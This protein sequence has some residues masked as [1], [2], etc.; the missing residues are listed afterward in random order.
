MKL[1]S[2]PGNEHDEVNPA[3]LLDTS[4]NGIL[5]VL[6]LS[7]IYCPNA[8]D[9]CA[10][11]RRCYTLRH[12]FCLFNIAPDNACIG[13]QVNECSYLGT[14]DCAGASGTE[15]DLVICKRASGLCV[16]RRV[17]VEG[18]Y[19][20]SHP[21]RLRRDTRIAG[22]PFYYLRPLDSKERERE[23]ERQRQAREMEDLVIAVR[24]ICEGCD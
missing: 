19:Q 13:T 21:A 17:G 18:A 8:N 10:L 16:M 1:H 7:N 23:T 3:E 12:A 14:A 15:D 24:D 9:L 4:C 5:Q 22:E 2:L 11:P 6:D 20:R